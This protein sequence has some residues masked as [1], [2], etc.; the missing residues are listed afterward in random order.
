[1]RPSTSAPCHRSRRPLPCT[2]AATGGSQGRGVWRTGRQ[3][4]VIVNM[5]P[6][7]HLPGLFSP[8][9]VPALVL[10]SVPCI[11][12][13]NGGP[14]P[15]PWLQAARRCQQRQPTALQDGLLAGKQVGSCIGHSLSLLHTASCQAAAPLGGDGGVPCRSQQCGGSD[16]G[17]DVARRPTHHSHGAALQGLSGRAA[18]LGALLGAVGGTGGDPQVDA[19]D[20]EC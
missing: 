7:N 19:M 16:V 12:S 10:C 6:I 11:I 18:A 14:L 4:A 1:M 15:L 13:S 3:G 5:C 20:Q 9:Q 8:L 2:A 17:F